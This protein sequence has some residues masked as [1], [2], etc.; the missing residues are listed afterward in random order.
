MFQWMQ[1]YAGSEGQKRPMVLCEYSHAM[2]NDPGDLED[3]WQIIYGSECFMGSFVWE[4][5]DHGICR[6][7]LKYLSYTLCRNKLQRLNLMTLALNSNI[8]KSKI[9]L[10]A[11]GEI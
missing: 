2:G 7:S 9:M 6:K 8:K 4:W 3:Y 11:V 1:D 5:A 10:D